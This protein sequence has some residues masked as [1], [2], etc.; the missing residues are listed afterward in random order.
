[1]VV[2]EGFLGN[3]FAVNECPVALEDV[4]DTLAPEVPDRRTDDA[5]AV[6]ALAA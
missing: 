6:D 5:A 4:D 3:C 2:S 1:M